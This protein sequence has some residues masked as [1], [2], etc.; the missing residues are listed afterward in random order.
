MCG[1]IS[2]RDG[3]MNFN[4]TTSSYVNKKYEE[5]YNKYKYIPIYFT[6][7]N[8]SEVKDICPTITTASNTSSGK[9]GTV[10]IIEKW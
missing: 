6:P 8:C 4:L 10:I 2:Y 1:F 3:K 7:Y 5:F 9:N